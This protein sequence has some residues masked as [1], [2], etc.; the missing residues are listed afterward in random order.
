MSFLPCLKDRWPPLIQIYFIF[1]FAGIFLLSSSVFFT[2]AFHKWWPSEREMSGE[3][4][5]RS[6]RG[7]CVWWRRQREDGRGSRRRRRRRRQREIRRDEVIRRGKEKEGAKK[8]AVGGG[9]GRRF[10]SC[11][12]F[13]RAFFQSNLAQRG[14]QGGDRS[15]RQTLYSGRLEEK[16]SRQ[17]RRRRKTE[18]QKNAV[19]IKNKSKVHQWTGARRRSVGWLSRQEILNSRDTKWH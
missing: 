13:I 16:Y 17:R 3:K 1:I 12:L 19:I 18:S 15:R 2:F 6:S 9:D 5:T 8:L 11:L 7:G 14:R 4:K 10:P